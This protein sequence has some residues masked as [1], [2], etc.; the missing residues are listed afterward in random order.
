MS[1]SRKK[2]KI[3]VSVKYGFTELVNVQNCPETNTTQV[4]GFCIDVF[5]AVMD[6]LPYYVP[7]EFIPFAEMKNTASSSYN[8][9]TYVNSQAATTCS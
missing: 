7:Y 8:D 1:A 2:L 6:K 5:D 9:L 3:G 4:T